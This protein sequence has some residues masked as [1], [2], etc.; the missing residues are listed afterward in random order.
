MGALGL[1]K[2][3]VDEEAVAEL[4]VTILLFIIFEDV[5]LSEI[6]KRKKFK[7]SEVKHA[8][9]GHQTHLQ[10]VNICNSHRIDMNRYHRIDI[11]R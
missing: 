1:R 3:V 5:R 11:E 2:F 8:K 7:V 4:F 10:Y 9:V 6:E